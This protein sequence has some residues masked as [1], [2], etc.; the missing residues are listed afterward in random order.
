MTRR[1][2]DQD[3]YDIQETLKS[4]SY[5]TVYRG[6]HT[7]TG[8]PVII[9]NISKSVLTAYP[10]LRTPSNLAPDIHILRSLT[11]HP[12]I[13][14]LLDWWETRSGWMIVYE[15]V[16]EPDEGIEMGVQHGEGWTAT[17]IAG[18]ASAVGFLHDRHVIL[19]DI[20]PSNIV[21]R[22][23]QDPASVVLTD[24]TNGCVVGNTP[25]TSLTSGLVGTPSW[26]SPEVLNNEP[27]GKEA[28]Y[29]SLGMLTLYFLIG[30]HPLGLNASPSDVLKRI[31]AGQLDTLPVGQNGRPITHEAV[32]FVKRL[33][34]RD[35][36]QRMS[37]A[38]ILEHPWILKRVDPRKL[39][40]IVRWWRRMPVSREGSPNSNGDYDDSSLSESNSEIS[41]DDIRKPPRVLRTARRTRS[42]GVA[43]P[44]RT[45]DLAAAW[46]PPNWKRRVAI[47]V[48]EG[49]F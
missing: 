4:S 12:H 44:M 24:F 15:Y 46:S 8:R 19:R 27:Y 7:L 5:K 31:E 9:K 47:E 11:H 20:K 39:R 1:A 6:F 30:N 32:D 49:L 16:G 14:E 26:Q 41:P 10:S 48:T 33:L 23:P 29:W 3:A 28:D 22:D 35:V 42:S 13:V 37:C 2:R 43:A 21:L 40:D 45:V 17:L 38:D 18:V 36:F 34:S 25:S